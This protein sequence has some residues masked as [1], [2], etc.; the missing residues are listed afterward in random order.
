MTFQA[1]A[2]LVMISGP[3]DTAEEVEAVKAT[4]AKWNS[5][6]AKDMG[7]VFVP[8]QH[9]STNTVPVLRAGVDGQAIINEQITDHADVILALFK[10]RLGTPTPPKRIFGHRRR[11]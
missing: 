3:G 5:S 1:I 11:G 7:V 10:Y 2:A 6:H 9:H 8:P 4:I